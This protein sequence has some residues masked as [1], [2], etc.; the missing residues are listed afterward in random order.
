MRGSTVELLFLF[1]ALLVRAKSNDIDSL[2]TQC[3]L[4][5]PLAL[6]D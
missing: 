1:Q 2:V 4:F 3:T 5:I 6:R